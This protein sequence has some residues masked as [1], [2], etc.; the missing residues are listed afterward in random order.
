M[1][2]S[3]RPIPVPTPESTPLPTMKADPIDSCVGCGSPTY[4]RITGDLDVAVLRQFASG[5]GRVLRHVSTDYAV[6]SFPNFFTQSEAIAS[7]DR[8]IQSHSPAPIPAPTPERPADPGL[9]DVLPT[10]EGSEPSPVAVALE[11]ESRS[12]LG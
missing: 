1:S 6:I 11:L 2:K 3:R 8:F 9:V 7:F 10:L 5:A 4:I 12:E